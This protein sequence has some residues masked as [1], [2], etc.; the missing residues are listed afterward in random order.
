MLRT[1]NSII[2]LTKIGNLRQPL[3]KMNFSSSYT[4]QQVRN[5]TT[6]ISATKELILLK[7]ESEKGLKLDEL[8]KDWITK[9]LGDGTFQNLCYFPETQSLVPNLSFQNFAIFPGSFNPLHEGHTKLAELGQEL[10]EGNLIYE[11]SVGNADK[12]FI[13]DSEIKQRLRG[14]SSA[15]T[16]T[17]EGQQKGG[18]QAQKQHPVLLSQAGLFKDKLQFIRDGVFVM[19]VDTFRRVFDLKY[20]NGQEELDNFCRLMQENGMKIAVGGRLVGSRAKT[21]SNSKSGEEE[22]FCVAVDYIDKVPAFYRS[23][24]HSFDGY[25]MDIS[26][27]ELRRLRTQ[28]GEF[29]DSDSDA[30]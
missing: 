15:R 1:F 18:E 29:E 22:E 28:S 13:T 25:R 5:K 4:S 12:G 9:N 17:Q 11:L 21:S 2:K 24:I 16:A 14:F 7:K 23:F 20:Y 27:T 26:S 10:C 19:G 3:L 30:S 6:T 8:P